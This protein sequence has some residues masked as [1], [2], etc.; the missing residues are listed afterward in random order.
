MKTTNRKYPSNYVKASTD[1]FAKACYI[2]G[3]SKY[4]PPYNILETIKDL[5]NDCLAGSRLSVPNID[6]ISIT[7]NGQILSFNLLYKTASGNYDGIGWS[8]RGWRLDTYCGLMPD[9]LHS[10]ADAMDRF[11]KTFD[12]LSF[13][14]DI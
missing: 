2:D 11:N 7:D 10:L 5:A 4:N 13:S 3:Y 1:T 14:T 8:G 9:E 12:G 6:A